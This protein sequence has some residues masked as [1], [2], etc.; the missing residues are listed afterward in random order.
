MKWLAPL[1]LAASLGAADAPKMF[2]SRTFPG[3]KPA[4]FQVTLARSGE[5]EYGEA[6]DDDQPLKFRL[7]DSEAAEVFALA[8]KLDFFKRAV[9]SPA[10]VAFM[11]TKLLRY[12]DGGQKTEVKFNY[13]DDVSARAL[14][15]WFERMGESARGCIELERAVKYD[16]LGVV[17]ALQY[18]EVEMSRKRL[19]G[20]EQFLPMLDRIINN[21]TFMHTARERAT[22][23]AATIRK[24]KQQGP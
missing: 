24:P 22:E 1:L 12:E 13:S 17:S 5:A 23:I 10:K 20:L 3:S 2:F 6:V 9:E 16:K 8:E 7:E 18:I 4:Y 19:V 14:A 21:A 15:D 11:G